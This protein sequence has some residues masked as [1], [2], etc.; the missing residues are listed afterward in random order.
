MQKIAGKISYTDENMD[1]DRREF[2]KKWTTDAIS[3]PM[4]SPPGTGSPFCR[5]G[6]WRFGG[7][8][9]CEYD[10]CFARFAKNI[11]G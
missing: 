4:R 5:A 6:G 9:A 11:S 1:R 7:F 2:V 10:T 3:C 8:M